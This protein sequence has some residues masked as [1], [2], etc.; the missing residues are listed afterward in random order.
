MIWS[1]F[2]AVQLGW[3]L[4]R[5]PQLT[6]SLHW[7]NKPSF[8]C[9]PSCH[10]GFF[11]NLEKTHQTTPTPSIF[12]SKVRCFSSR[13]LGLWSRV[14]ATPSHALPFF[15][16]STAVLSL[17]HEN[18]LSFKGP[19]TLTVAGIVCLQKKIKVFHNANYVGFGKKKWTVEE[20][21]VW[22]PIVL[23]LIL[24]PKA[25]FESACYHTW[26]MLEVFANHKR[27]LPKRAPWKKHTSSSWFGTPILHISPGEPLSLWIQ[28][29]SLSTFPH[30]KTLY[31][32][33]V[34]HQI[35]NFF[36]R[37]AT[38]QQPPYN[39][40]T[41]R[42]VQR[43]GLHRTPSICHMSHRNFVAA[44]VMH[45]QRGCS[46]WHLRIPWVQLTKITAARWWLVIVT[47]FVKPRNDWLYDGTIRNTYIYIYVYKYMMY[48]Y[49]I[50][51]M[52]I[53]KNMYI[54][55][56]VCYLSNIILCTAICKYIYT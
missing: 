2:S 50:Q 46:P 30:P 31:R 33:K 21:N 41:G 49:T 7:F 52:C 22:H 5:Q 38:N 39:T 17:V 45:S 13:K 26:D 3:F 28:V 23:I 9:Q 18:S 25:I 34:K 6:L 32:I 37:N 36:T 27:F 55:V 44:M 53:Y 4:W 29:L 20:F 8:V 10:L 15:V 40:K 14:K 43:Y 24:I 51:Y 54:Y 48:L 42:I 19:S 56:C 47:H 12:S 16:P 1:A 35:E 11:P